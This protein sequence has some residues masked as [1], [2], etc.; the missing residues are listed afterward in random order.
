MFDPVPGAPASPLPT[1]KPDFARFTE[2]LE[3]M[4]FSRH[5][6]YGEHGR[7]RFDAFERQC[8]HVSVYIGARSDNGGPLG[9][10]C[11]KAVPVQWRKPPAFAQASN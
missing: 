1:G 9:P 4:G 11:V 10:A 6:R 2:A 3:S 7:W 5:P 8:L